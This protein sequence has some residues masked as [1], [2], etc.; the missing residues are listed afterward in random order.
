VIRRKD[1]MKMLGNPV[2]ND[3]LPVEDLIRRAE[4]EAAERAKAITERARPLDAQ[5]K[6][7]TSRWGARVR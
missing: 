6:E 2:Y 3:A 4:R 7:L 5:V 1:A